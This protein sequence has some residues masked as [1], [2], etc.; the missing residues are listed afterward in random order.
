M[1]KTP[2]VAARR[3]AS[4][5]AGLVLLAG[6]VCLVVNAFP[7]TFGRSALTAASPYMVL[8]AS[9][10]AAIAGGALAYGTVRASPRL[11]ARPIGASRALVLVSVGVALLAPLTIHAIAST[12]VETTSEGFRNW[13]AAS[14]VITSTAH[15]AFAGMVGVRAKRLANG[16]IAQRTQSIYVTTVVV[17]AIPFALLWGLPPLIVA[18]TGGFLLPAIRAMERYAIYDRETITLP[19]ARAI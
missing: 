15:I 6:M 18:M 1:F 19:Y 16:Q 2:A 5:T 12:V 17:S 14:L 7:D 4:A 3:A 8:G 10:L 9:W 11:S 13:V